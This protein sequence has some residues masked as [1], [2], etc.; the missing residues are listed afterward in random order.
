MFISVYGDI[1]PLLYRPIYFRVGATNGDCSI[2][3]IMSESLAGSITTAIWDDSLAD[4]HLLLVLVAMGD[5]E[6]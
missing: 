1:Q 4:E 3:T 5:R 2:T 6:K